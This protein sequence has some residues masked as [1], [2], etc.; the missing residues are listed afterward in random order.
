MQYASIKL[1]F[2]K[3][4]CVIVYGHIYGKNQL[5]YQNRTEHN[6]FLGCDVY[7]YGSNELSIIK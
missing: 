4:L 5:V 1:S 6:N 3:I 7:T 2:I